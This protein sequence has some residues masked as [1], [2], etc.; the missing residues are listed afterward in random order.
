MHNKKCITRIWTLNKKY[1]LT[2][3]QGCTTYF[4]DSARNISGREMGVRSGGLGAVPPVGFRG[5]APG[6]GV[7]GR[8]PPKVDD[9]LLIQQQ[10]FALIAM[11][12]QKFSCN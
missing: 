10:F 6:Q 7:S 3:K 11:F 9:D 2:L 4:T 12:M 1:K 5:K 8:S